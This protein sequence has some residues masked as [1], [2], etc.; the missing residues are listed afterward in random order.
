MIDIYSDNI[1]EILDKPLD[2]LTYVVFDLE[3]TGVNPAS[4]DRIIEIGAVKLDYNLKI[5][6]NFNT[7][8]NPEIKIPDESTFING[9]TDSNVKKAPKSHYAIYDFMEFSKNSILV[10]HDTSKDITFLKMEMRQYLEVLPDFIILDTLKIAKFLYPSNHKHSLDKL[11]ELFNI[12]VNQYPYKR[13]RALFDAK[14]TAI[15]FKI[16]IYKLLNYY[17]LTLV[18]LQELLKAF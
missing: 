16:M 18:E 2:R 4:G 17:C 5:S 6:D 3:T 9:I 8:V 10:G 12:K 11:I 14:A 13:H 7:F 15:A 1:I